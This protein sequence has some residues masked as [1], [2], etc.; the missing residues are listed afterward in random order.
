MVRLDAGV[1][2]SPDNLRE[3]LESIGR[4]RGKVTRTWF[5]RL[6]TAYLRYR[7]ERGR[8]VAPA[9]QRA[10]AERARDVIRAACIKSAMGGAASGLVTT[11]AVLAVAEAPAGMLLAIP[12]AALAIGGE[13]IVRSL[14]HLDMTCDLADIFGQR[15]DPEEPTDFWQLYALAFRTHAHESAADPGNDLLH[16]IGEV[17]AQIGESIAE[18]IL[19]ESMI[20]NILPFA[21]IAT[22]SVANWRR[23]RRLGDTA[24]RY[25]RYRRAMDD[26]MATAQELVREHLDLL[27]EGL[28]FLFVADGQLVPE[29]V[30]LLAGL[31]RRLDP[32]TRAAV[33]ARFVLDETDWLERLPRL[34][35][36][37][38]AP[39]L[40]ALEVA[41][42]VDKAVS[43]PEQ[44][45]LARA[46]RVLG[47]EL[48]M[49]RVDA[50]IKDFEDV[51]VLTRS[52]GFEGT[53]AGGHVAKS[54]R[55][56]NT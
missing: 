4:G 47:R 8:N 18:K 12:G 24:R 51:G 7:A 25:L 38:R 35:E 3:V 15:F 40:Y 29:E 30:T 13:M 43:L 49:R 50:M 26:T 31:L 14:I 22:S 56:A 46:A 16:R 9:A 37:V 48:D 20:K 44:R 27:V 54:D 17:D 42:A 19:G 34:A 32:V 33:E 6:V 36:A 45:I 11:G 1:A 28:W 52:S 55:R 2:V 53:T 23:T 39:F 10:E 21:G 41:A 5:T